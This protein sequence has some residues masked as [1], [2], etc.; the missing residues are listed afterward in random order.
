MCVCCHNCEKHIM[1][2][3]AGKA[4]FQKKSCCNLG[5]ENMAVNTPRGE[6][7]PEHLESCNHPWYYLNLQMCEEKFALQCFLVFGGIS[8]HFF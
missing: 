4:E 7:L 8:S 2:V 3:S 6:N 5:I 1:I